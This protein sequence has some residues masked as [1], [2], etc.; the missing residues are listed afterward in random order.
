MVVRKPDVKRLLAKG[1]SGKEAGK[2]V[3]EHA[4]A[5]DRGG[6]GFLSEKDIQTLQAS[7]TTQQDIRDY[8]RVLDVYRAVF[9]TI[10][11][12]KI[13][14]L[15]AEKDLRS[16]ESQLDAYDLSQ[17]LSQ[18]FRFLPTILTE[19]DYQAVK[20]RQ[21]RRL[22]KR[23]YSLGEVIQSRTEELLGGSEEA[24]EVTDAVW[25]KAWKAADQEVQKLIDAG[26]LRPL[27]LGHNASLLPFA[28]AKATLE[29]PLELEDL[30]GDE[31]PDEGTADHHAAYLARLEEAV[32]QGDLTEGHDVSRYCGELDEGDD[33]ERLLHH[34]LSGDQ[35]Y[36]AGLPEWRTWIDDFKWY[37]EPDYAGGV[38]DDQEG[39]VAVLV[40]DGLGGSLDAKGHFNRFWLDQ[41]RDYTQ[42]KSVEEQF[43]KE[44]GVSMED[45]LQKTMSRVRDQARVLLAY[46][47]VLREAGEV[48]GIELGLEEALF[49]EDL[50]KTAES[51][52]VTA[53]AVSRWRGKV[54]GPKLKPLDLDQLK[55]DKAT[56]ETLHERFSE[57]VFGGG[58]GPGWWKEASDG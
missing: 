33:E 7:L 24:E 57:G 36:K 12:A 44:K 38:V 1:L 39:G 21:K 53:K 31:E 11:E 47:Q 5:I 45:L 49:L 48:Y 32:A 34:Y 15:S 20:A 10:Q 42:V 16:V 30:T 58:F 43:A 29:D 8:N 56:V 40:A 25:A 26:K 9:L 50:R 28:E 13:L 46:H 51:Y 54:R 14:S 35:L 4:Y 37:E 17:R 22:R 27:R 18:V 19:K 6:S 52:S 41:L 3:V 2:L 55:P 23:L